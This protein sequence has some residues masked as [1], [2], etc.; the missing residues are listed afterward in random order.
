M[1]EILIFLAAFGC[2]PAVEIV[3]VEHLSHPGAYVNGQIWLR[4]DA[5][6][7]VLVHEL[8]HACGHDEAGAHR[9]ETIWR[10]QDV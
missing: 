6:L 4:P 9:L 5:D 8:A 1:K 2:H 7:G 3:E 10:N